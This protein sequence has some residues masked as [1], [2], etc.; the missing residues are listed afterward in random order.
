MEQVQGCSWNPGAPLAL[1][2]PG[3]LSK[4]CAG[5]CVPV[6]AHMRVCLSVCVCAFS[7]GAESLWQEF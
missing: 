6:C 3:M 7:R 1:L 5:V 2:S 4:A